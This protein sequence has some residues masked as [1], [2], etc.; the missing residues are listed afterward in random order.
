MINT[1]KKLLGWR[2]AL[3][4]AGLLACILS[5]C[6]LPSKEAL[7]FTARMPEP[8]EMSIRYFN[9][10]S[11]EKS[12]DAVL[13][14]TPDGQQLL[15]DAGVPGSGPK[16]D[17]L[18]RDLGIEKLDVVISTHPHIDHIG[19]LTTLLRTMPVSAYYSNGVPHTTDTYAKVQAALKDEGVEEHI[20]QEG[21]RL[22]LSEGLNIEVLNPDPVSIGP[23]EKQRSTE[24]LNNHSLVL[25]MTYKDTRVLFTGDIY[26]TAEY[27]LM[28]RYKDQLKADLMHAPHH[29]DKTSSS[30]KF[31]DAVGP[32][33]VIISANMLQS[34]DVLKRYE[35]KADHVWT[36]GLNGNMLFILDG[37]K[38]E[39]VPERMPE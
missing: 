4:W 3:V 31:I 12:G 33:Q 24:E 19:G 38:I 11:E 13:V 35:K 17:E 1:M 25:L 32:E 15:L 28:E 22:E 6:S 21:D 8:G 27:E 5:G 39:A 20:L 14:T 34:L 23:L 10:E 16:L 2:K 30:G 9:L 18:L 7:D 37:K 29:G 26:K 36:T